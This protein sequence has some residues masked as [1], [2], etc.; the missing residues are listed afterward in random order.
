MLRICHYTHVIR[1]EV[2]VTDGLLYQFLRIQPTF[3]IT[4]EMFLHLLILYFMSLLKV[5][6][7]YLQYKCENVYVIVCN[8]DN[9]IDIGIMFEV[10]IKIGYLY[11]T[12]ITKKKLLKCGQIR[13]LL[14]LF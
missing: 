6:K 3:N 7:L 8:I 2:F 11:L 14:V 10:Q 12:K 9:I 1:N 4:S 13:N 5:I